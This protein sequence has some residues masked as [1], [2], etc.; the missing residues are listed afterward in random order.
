MHSHGVLVPTAS[1][2]CAPHD[3]DFGLKPCALCRGFKR[4][5]STTQIRAEMRVVDT[6]LVI[7]DWKLFAPAIWR[8]WRRWPLSPFLAAGRGPLGTGWMGLPDGFHRADRVR[9]GW[10]WPPPW[11]VFCGPHAC[12]SCF[13]PIFICCA[14]FLSEDV[15]VILIHLYLRRFFAQYLPVCVAT[16]RAVGRWKSQNAHL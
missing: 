15:F 2:C 14:P 13:P 12:A 9:A 4:T 11:L 5:V 16:P 3:A 6:V 7:K 10:I 8:L 1:L